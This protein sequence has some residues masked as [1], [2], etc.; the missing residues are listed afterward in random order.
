MA[1]VTPA[2]VNGSK[3]LVLVPTSMVFE[4]KTFGFVVMNLVG[5]TKKTVPVSKALVQRSRALVVVLITRAY[6]TRT[7]GF[8][9]MT[10]VGKTKK[11]VP[12]TK[13][14]VWDCKLNCVTAPPFL[15]SCS[16]WSINSRLSVRRPHEQPKAEIPNYLPI[17]ALA[18]SLQSGGAS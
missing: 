13:K 4:M 1:F 16:K 17:K 9:S 5:M 15:Q 6:E 18:I 2:M 7:F 10:L 3:T 11:R 8:V 14:I 12:A